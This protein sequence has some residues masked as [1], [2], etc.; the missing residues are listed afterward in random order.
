M[1]S[2]TGTTNGS[3]NQMNEVEEAQER[4][5][6]KSLEVS[7]VSA[8]NSVMVGTGEGLRQTAGAAGQAAAQGAKAS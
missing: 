5:T 8:Q 4:M 1:T 2:I 3:I 6:V 7:C